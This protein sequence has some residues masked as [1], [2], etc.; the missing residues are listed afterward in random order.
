MDNAV[1]TFEEAKLM[2]MNKSYDYLDQKNRDFDHDY[3]TFFVMVQTLKDDLAYT[4]E[5]NFCSVW[6]TGQGIKFLDKF[7]KVICTCINYYLLCKYTFSL[8]LQED[9]VSH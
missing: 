3:T 8:H 5:T 4:I 9:N 7:E 2:V 6:E 1:R